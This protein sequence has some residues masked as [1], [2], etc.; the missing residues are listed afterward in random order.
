MIKTRYSW[1]VA[2]IAALCLR[3]AIPAVGAAEAPLLPP[4]PPKSIVDLHGHIAGIGAGGSGCFV[5][6]A[7]QRNVRFG[8]FLRAFGVTREELE[9]EGDVR[10]VTRLRERLAGSRCVGRVVVLALDGVVDERGELDRGRTEMY[11]PNEFVAAQ[12][13]AH[14]ELLFGASVNPYRRDALERLEWAKAHGAVLVKWLPSVQHIDPADPRL[15]PFY[16]KLV[17]LRLPLLTHTGRERAFTAAD[18]ALCDPARLRLALE[19]GVTVIA[20]HAATQGS[21][22]GEPALD[23][24][25]RLMREYPRL[26][27]DCSSLTQLNK[28]THL[29]RVLARPEFRGRLVYGTD[30][31]LPTMRA[32]VSPWYYP[33]RLSWRQKRAIAAIENLWDRD[34]ALKAALGLPAEVW[35]QQFSLREN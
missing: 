34:V 17:E 23:R 7:M 22:E 24:L 27:A 35:T 33:W 28:R 16:R 18:D 4:L 19:Q 5:S 11:V 3:L 2:G 30:Y 10:V 1:G 26:Y 21:Y 14:P 9:R 13:A 32:L 25:T 15:I 6:A 20:A 12:A 8:A 29:A 31:P